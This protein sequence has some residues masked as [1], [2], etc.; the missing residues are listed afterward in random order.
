MPKAMVHTSPES[1]P[2]K[3]NKGRF[4]GTGNN[5]RL[6]RVECRGPMGGD[7]AAGSHPSDHPLGD[8]IHTQKS[9]LERHGGE[10]IQA[11]NQI[12]SRAR[13]KP[14]KTLFT[15]GWWFFCWKAKITIRNLVS[16]KREVPPAVT[17][18]KKEKGSTCRGLAGGSY[19][20]CERSQPTDS[21]GSTRS[22]W[23]VSGNFGWNNE[24]GGNI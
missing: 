23:G 21:K 4:R 1:G 13:K 6:K 15:N 14:G 3:N 9:N 10:D 17:N 8:L 19:V 24:E 12:R 22:D 5:H 2:K 20:P 7:K 11:S 18:V 16:E